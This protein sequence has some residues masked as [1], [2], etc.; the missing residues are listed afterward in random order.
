[1]KSQISEHSLGVI[2]Q[3]VLDEF[4]VASRKFGRFHNA[5]EGYAVLQEEVDE[6]WEAVK[7]NQNNP[8]REDRILREA[9]QVAAMAIRI[10]HDVS[11]EGGME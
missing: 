2:N 8:E 5:H 7:L 10:L 4:R 3:A 1:M 9:T 6:L 11:F